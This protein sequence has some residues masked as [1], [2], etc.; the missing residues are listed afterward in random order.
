MVQDV[1]R[2]WRYRFE[3]ELRC[4]ESL[5][6]HFPVINADLVCA[7][8]AADL[9]KKHIGQRIIG[10]PVVDSE[11]T[12][13]DRFPFGLVTQV[14]QSIVDIEQLGTLLFFFPANEDLD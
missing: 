2:D 5:R 1:Y 14:R 12:V 11:A 13:V 8:I 6:Q 3:A 9:R 4:L 7:R 10:L